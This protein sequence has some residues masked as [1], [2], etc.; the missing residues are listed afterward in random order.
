MLHKPSCNTMSTPHYLTLHHDYAATARDSAP[1]L[2]SYPIEL[3]VCIRGVVREA[4]PPRLSIAM[5]PLV[6]MA[7]S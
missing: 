6:P 3:G 4:T 7:N 2:L 1:D 5:E